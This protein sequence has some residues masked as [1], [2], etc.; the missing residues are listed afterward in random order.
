MARI[1]DL[2]AGE[3]PPD[4][5]RW[6]LVH[7]EEGVRAPGVNVTQHDE[8]ATFALSGDAAAF[9]AAIAKACEWE[10]ANGVAAVYV[11]R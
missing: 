9:D 5:E 7:R 1:V 6:A 3:N 8:G 11:R 4:G 2:A 10:D